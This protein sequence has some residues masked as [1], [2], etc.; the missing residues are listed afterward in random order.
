MGTETKPNSA[1]EKDKYFNRLDEDFGNLFVSITRDLLF[2]VESIS[3][4]NDFCLKLESLN[5]NTDEMR[6]HHLEN[7]LISLSLAH[8]E[9]IE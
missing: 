6:G 3:T 2:H 5:G 7:E 9:T 8:Y 1:I 4:P